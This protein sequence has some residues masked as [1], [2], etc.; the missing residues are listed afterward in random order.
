MKACSGVLGQSLWRMSV[1]GSVSC[2]G[3]CVGWSRLVV[4]FLGIYLE[5]QVFGLGG[6]IS[7]GLLGLTCVHSRSAAGMRREGG[8]LCLGIDPPNKALAVERV[9]SEKRVIRTSEYRQVALVNSGLV[10]VFV[11]RD[12][13]S[14]NGV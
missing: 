13:I 14:L 9:V 5:A 2:A 11:E 4:L 7:W 10:D 6:M 1:F 12:V 8:L 3:F